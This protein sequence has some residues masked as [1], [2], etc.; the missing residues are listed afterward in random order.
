MKNL[1]RFLLFFAAIVAFASCIDDAISEDPRTEADE[2]ASLEVYIDTLHNRGLDVDT[3]AMGIYYIIDSLGNGPYP[4][5]G[6][7]C[8]VKYDGYTL[9]GYMFDS[10]S[11]HNTDGKYEF[12]LGNP[13]LIEG[14]DNGVQV[15]NQGSTVYLIIP[16]EFAYGAN[17]VYPSIGPYQTLIFKIEMVEIKQAY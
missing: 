4:V 3:T 15:I 7:T 11:R 17:G 10:S 16:S 5:P 14:W 9:D 6:D 12:I 2:L 13:P 8:I 1:I